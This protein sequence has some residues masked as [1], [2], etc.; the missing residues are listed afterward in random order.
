[1]NLKD[2]TMHD[3]WLAI[4]EAFDQ[5]RV[6]FPTAEAQSVLDS[7]DL[8]DA[9][10]AE[11]NALADDPAALAESDSMVHIV[12]MMLLAQR[13]DRR[14]AAP[15][16][17]LASGSEDEVA[18]L[19]GDFLTEDW[20]VAMAA[21]ASADHL[22][23]F[24]ENERHSPWARVMATRAL[25]TQVYENELERASAIDYAIAL[26]EHYLPGVVHAQTDDPNDLII[27]ALADVVGDLGDE[28]QHLQALERWFELG[29]LDPQHAGI[30]WYRRELSRPYE[31]RRETAMAR[32]EAYPRDVITRMSAWYCYSEQCHR[33]E[34]YRAAE[35]KS[36][37]WP[38]DAGTFERDTIKV[39]R[40]DPCP[41]GSGKKYKKCC[42]A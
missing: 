25:V 2:S 21:V 11:L 4:R 41:C 35:T 42:G 39:G 12:G 33:E 13:R 38:A 24:L 3:R 8:Q 6:G 15:L 40:N 16:I 34:A 20:G 5:P 29:V 26:G 19:W 31:E 28:A 23:A 22:K 1:M 18:S 9:L 14:L 27:D 17:R 37:L 30:D 10:L 36:V 7:P 32:N